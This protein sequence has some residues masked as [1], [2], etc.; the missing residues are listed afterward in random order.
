MNIFTSSKHV[1]QDELNDANTRMK[2]A[3]SIGIPAMIFVIVILIPVIQ[4]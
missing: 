3:L 4:H 1:A 2:I